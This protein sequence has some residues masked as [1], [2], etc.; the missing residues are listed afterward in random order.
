MFQFKKTE[1]KQAH[2][3]GLIVKSFD[4]QGDYA[5]QSSPRTFIG[6]EPAKEFLA[7]TQTAQTGF[8]CSPEEIFFSREMAEDSD[9]ANSC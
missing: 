9:F 8:S 5:G 6:V 7:D 4:K 1:I 3:L 2:H